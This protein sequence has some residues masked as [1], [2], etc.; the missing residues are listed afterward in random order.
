MAE[1]TSDSTV[2]IVNTQARSGE[3][4]FRAAQRLLHERGIALDDAVALTEP[5]RIAEQV[6]QS[7]REGA[8][9]IIAGGGD[10][11]FSA[12][13]HELAGSDTTLALLPLGTGNDFARG[14]AIPLQLEK[15]CDVIVQGRALQ[16]DLGRVDGRHFLNAISVGF[17]PGMTRRLSRSLKKLGPPGYLVAA[18][19]AVAAHR[20]FEVTI[21]SGDAVST[22]RVLQVVVGNGRYHGGGLLI[23]PDATLRDGMLDLYAIGAQTLGTKDK[24]HKLGLSDLWTLARVGARI[25]SG[26]HVEDRSVLH[27]R[28]AHV[29]LNATPEQEVDVDGELFGTSPISVELVPRALRVVAPP[30]RG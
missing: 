5:D 6:R 24:P 11:T 26:N 23:S 4:Q 25:R 21:S 2:L 17:T 27:L 10:G 18:A 12:I 1:R 19:A 28:S 3:R 8:K 7:V 29:Q 14:L 13:A 22:L 9:R 15:A 16:V 30:P 20:P